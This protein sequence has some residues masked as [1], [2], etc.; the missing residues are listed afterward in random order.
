MLKMLVVDDEKTIRRG[1]QSVID[2]TA[3]GI[4]IVGAAKNGRE[5]LE[6]VRRL[7]PDIVLADIRMPV[8]DGLEFIRHL[9]DERPA[10]RIVLLSGHSEFGYAQEALR[11]GVEEYILK[12]FGAEKLLELMLTLK[13][14]IITER[15]R[16]TDRRRRELLIQENVQVLR[17]ELV[18]TL[19]AH[20]AAEGIAEKATLVGTRLTGPRYRVTV[21]GI[22]GLFSSPESGTAEHLD[23]LRQRLLGTA[24][25]IFGDEP[26]FAVNQFHQLVSV[27]CGA[28]IGD[29][30]ITDRFTAM[31]EQFASRVDLSV[32]T[33][34]GS[35]VT[36]L[37]SLPSSFGEA[38]TALR[39]RV[40]RGKG[41]VL[42][43][44]PSMETDWS[45]VGF[46]LPTEGETELMSAL[47]NADR[48]RMKSVLSGVFARL[49]AE[50]VA[51]D[52]AREH[53]MRL[54]VMCAFVSREAGGDGQAR[55]KRDVPVFRRLDHAETIDE[56]HRELSAYALGYLDD[57]HDHRQPQF[58]SV[59]RLAVEYIQKT[60]DTPLSLKGLAK[61]L[62]VTPGYLSRAFK[63]DT[64][65]SFLDYL[66]EYRVERAVTMLRRTT[67]RAYEIAE[68]CGYRDYKY[69]HSVFRKY[70]GTS[71]SSYRRAFCAPAEE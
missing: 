63:D 15:A 36:E 58:R 11:L 69:F 70:T 66:H 45:D 47:L 56:M 20:G 37:A 34:V 26:L 30:W 38:S 21:T 49:K 64:G 52:A 67:L 4:T 54:V 24:R 14:R 2:W 1:I 22:D 9:K 12:P 27:F 57:I 17:A 48:G 43:H 41:K 10:T 25:T 6:Q 19:V 18:R 71:P 61:E 46:E 5:G 62:S 42:F 33:G 16:E 23:V 40:Y 35:L 39:Y 28:G 65:K 3:H 60:W 32:T 55:L 8:M 53:A 7:L 13:K 50:M 59:V 51:P 44:E 31:K 68:K 29:R